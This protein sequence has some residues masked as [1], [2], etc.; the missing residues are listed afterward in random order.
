MK[1]LVSLRVIVCGLLLVAIIPDAEVRAADS[2]QTVKIGVLAT[3]T[4]SGFSL[5]RNT[6]AALRI[7]AADLQNIHP[8]YN[9][10]RF[11]FLVRNTQHDPTRALSAI[12]DLYARGVKIVIGPQ[13]SSEVAMIKP[14]ADAH[15]I[16]V[17][18][19]GSTASSLAIPGDNILRFCPN[20]RREA[21]AL[22]ALLQHDR[23][24][25]IVPLWRNDAGNNGLHDSVKIR[26]QALGGRVTS[27][28]RYEPT[29][30][31]FS[32]ATD[33]VASQ[34]GSLI[35]SGI[36]PS[37]VAVYLA[38]FDEAVDVFHSAKDNP[39]LANTTW[40][41]SDG[42]ALS[43][44]LTADQSAAA[45][46]AS[47]DYPNPIFGLPDG[48]RNRWQPIANEIEART[49]IAPD[50]FALSAYD[51]LFVVNL[52]LQNPKPLKNF[53]RFKAEVIEEADHY[54]GITGS[55]ALDAAGDRLA[56][57]FDFWAVRLRNGSY[58]W[59]RVAAY[60]NGTLRVF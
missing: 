48:L 47:V 2:Q 36:N 52:A 33:S 3:L 24:R 56:G 50:A 32:A 5:G 15:D 34:V 6:V 35:G 11:R 26:F 30:T 1:I 60:S 18:S 7:A 16:L 43:A 59:V 22:V 13:T 31:D 25:A 17:I 20:D 40:Y 58:T 57:D 27:G 53:N 21:E 14:F 44:A 37:A 4:G 49:G 45:F 46:A 51:A 29:T 10:V 55:T 39:T 38:A 9:P 42:V 8:Q 19:Q 28:F 23:I 12:Q 41:G 54:H